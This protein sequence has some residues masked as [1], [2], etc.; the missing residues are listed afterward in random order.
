[1]DDR[2]DCGNDDCAL[3]FDGK[4]DAVWSDDHECADKIEIDSPNDTGPTDN[5]W[6]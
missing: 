2:P 3:N 6:D 1:M 5:G 4:C